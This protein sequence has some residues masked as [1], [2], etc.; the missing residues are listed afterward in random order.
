MEN[1]LFR[2]FAPKIYAVISRFSQNIN[3]ECN[4][5][6]Q[7]INF[8]LREHYFHLKDEILRIHSEDYVNNPDY[9]KYKKGD[10]DDI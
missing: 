9:N 4:N 5:E 1:Y 2:A 6:Q 8:P 10:D 3:L 7:K